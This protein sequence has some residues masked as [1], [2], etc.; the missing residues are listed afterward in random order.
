MTAEIALG[1]VMGFIGGFVFTILLMIGLVSKIVHIARVKKV[2]N[3]DD[4]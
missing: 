3:E 2:D 4:E 1:I